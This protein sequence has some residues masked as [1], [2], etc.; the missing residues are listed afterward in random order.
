[1]AECA[2]AR[3]AVMALRHKISTIEGRLPERLTASVETNRDDG[4]A[5]LVRRDGLA[6]GDTFATG[7]ATLDNA[8]GGG[9]PRGA[10]IELH[11]RQIREAAAVTGFALALA[12]RAGSRDGKPLL[13][14][15]TSEILAE[16]GEPYAPGIFGRFGISSG[17][18]LVCGV[19][20][21]EDAL[22][23]AEEA[24]IL[25]ALSAVLIEVAGSARRLDLT[26]TR[27]LHMRARKAG[28]P[29][30]LLRQA[31]TPE[32]TAA[33]VRLIITPAAAGYRTMMGDPFPGSIGPPACTVLVARSRAAASVTVT[34]EWNEDEHVFQERYG[35]AVRTQDHGALVSPPSGR[36][37][38]ED[39]AGPRLA[40]T[41]RR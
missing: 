33:S 35:H 5:V 16:A 41:V 10:L 37:H 7:V 12:A 27:R 20:R 34:L 18:L 25:R 32:P 8:L 21:V 9:L 38:P 24:A 4:D 1:M 19:R 36:P 31:G 30:F 17:N 2:V 28:R 11:G 29:I 26:A 39:E 14:I 22:W 3:E 40:V 13:W 23:I 15:G 6:G